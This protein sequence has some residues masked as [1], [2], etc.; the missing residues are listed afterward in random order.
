M[1]AQLTGVA[2]VGAYTFLTAVIFWYLI[3]VSVGLRVTLHEEIEG[4][5]IGEHGNSAYPDFV[6][7]K[8]SFT[9]IGVAEAEEKT[10]EFSGKH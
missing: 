2:A 5:D 10:P 6:T 7:R 8:P 3:K 9:Y 4:L 1:T